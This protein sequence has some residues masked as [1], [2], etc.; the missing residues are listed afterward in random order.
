MAVASTKTG[1]LLPTS[2]KVR[3]NLSRKVRCRIVRTCKMRW[4]G[5][6]A[7]PGGGGAHLVPHTDK[8]C[9]GRGAPVLHDWP[10]GA[11]KVGVNTATEASVRADHHKQVISTSL[12]LHNLCL[13]QHS[14]TR[15]SQTLSLSLSLC[16]S[17]PGQ[18][19]HRSWPASTVVL[20]ENTWQL[21][22]S[23][24]TLLSS[25]YSSLTSD[26]QTLHIQREPKK[27]ADT[28][29]RGQLTFLEGRHASRALPERAR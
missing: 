17:Y 20:P 5:Q 1:G 11:S 12:L 26:E 22:P 13:L 7:E 25:L 9:V 15:H 14:Y 21:T 10:D 28:S 19:H 2:L 8:V 6:W 18:P 23:S 16:L 3:S 4:Q 24:W 29:D 27:M